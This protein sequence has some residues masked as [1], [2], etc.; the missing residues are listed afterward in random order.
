MAYTLTQAEFVRLKSR[1]TRV[2]NSKDN[3]KII[4]ECNRANAIFE[5]KGFPDNWSD[6]QRAKDDAEFAK[7]RTTK[8]WL[9]G[10]FGK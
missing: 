8:D 10:H 4:A 5:E 7:G 6:W 1:L 2:V 3:D 9:W